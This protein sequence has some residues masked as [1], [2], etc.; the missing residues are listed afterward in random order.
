M[1]FI[2]TAFFEEFALMIEND[3]FDLRL[4]LKTLWNASQTIDDGLERF[5]ANRC[6]FGCA[7]IFRLKY[8]RR[9]SEFCFLASLPFFDGIDFVSR[10]FQPESKLGFQ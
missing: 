9:F 2:W 5:L 8:R 7:C 6:R 10:H 3:A 1:P 4:N